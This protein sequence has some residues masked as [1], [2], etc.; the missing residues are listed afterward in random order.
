MRFPSRGAW[1][2]DTLKEIFGP[3]ATLHAFDDHDDAVAMATR[4]GAGMAASIWTAR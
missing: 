3:L 4:P 1:S 2:I